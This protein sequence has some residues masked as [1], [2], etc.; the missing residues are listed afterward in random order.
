M[1]KGLVCLFTLLALAQCAMAQNTLVQLLSGS[2]KDHT[3][4]WQFQVSGGRNSGEWKTIPVPSSWEMQGFG[5]YRY[6]SDWDGEPAPD[7]QGKYKYSFFAPADWQGSAIEI[8]FGGVMTDAEVRVNGELLGPVHRGGFYEFRYPLDKHLHYGQS[9]LLEVNVSRFSENKSINLAE[10]RADFWMFSG[11]YRPVWVEVKPAQHIRQVEIKASHTGEFQAHLLVDGIQNADRISGQITRL[12]GKRVGSGFSVRLKPGQQYVDLHAQIDGVRP[13]SAEDP[14]RYKVVFELKA[15]RKVLHQVDEVFGFRT[16]EL[17]P[18]DGL[19]VNDQKVHLKG[20]NRHSFWPD[21]GATTSESISRNDIKLIKAMNMNAVRTAHAPP[22]RH[23]LDVADELGVYVLDELTGWQDAYD[24]YTGRVLVQEMVERDRNHPSVIMWA[25]GNEGG[26]NKSLDVDFARW[27]MQA[28]PVVHP[29]GVHGGI[30]ASHYE[31]YD[32]CAGSFFGGPELFMPT[33]FL[34]ALYDGGGGAGLDDWWNRMLQNPLAIG[35]FIWSFA[36]EGI[37]RDDKSGALDTAGNSAPDGVLGPYRE[38]EGSFYAIREIWSPVYFPLSE[39]SWLPSSFNGQLHVENRYDF[40]NLNQLTFTWELRDFNNPSAKGKGHIVKHTGQVIADNIAPGHSGDLNLKLPEDWHD[41]DS[42]ALTATNPQG[43]LIHTWTWMTLTPAE[44]AKRSLST[45]KAV[46]VVKADESSTAIKLQAGD[47]TVTIDKQSGRLA[48]VVRGDKQ[49]SL[50]N[51]PRLVSGKGALE[52][53]SLWWEGD[54]PVVSAQY[55]GEMSQVQWRLHPNGWLQMNYGY[56]LPSGIK[57]DYLGITF[58]Y[59]ESQALGITWLGRG[60]YRVWKNRLKGMAFDIWHTDY[61][62]TVTGQAGTY[63][64]FKGFYRD[65]YWGVLE[66]RELPITLAV[67]TENTFLRLFTPR[68]PA[69]P[70]QTHLQFPAGDISI[71]QGIAP[72]GTKFHTAD[73][74]GVQG[75]P[76]RIGRLGQSYG[77]ELYLYFGEPAN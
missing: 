61:N 10:R 74:M 52:N 37:V 58:D 46:G 5:S 64:E 72:I 12:D 55:K 23:F 59:P 6:W 17:R 62:D 49:V 1:L 70:A 22:D 50:S 18:R 60:P 48:R 76:N 3:V 19:Y 68:E 32:C 16:I 36:D 15:G 47:L 28:R 77:A 40:T 24:T 13:W 43:Q 71:L 9:N 11:I 67:N 26:W 75:A 73:E 56:H 14:Q 54:V 31:T 51:G 27:D 25:N 4:D 34:H 66:T 30:D 2:D 53:V 41:Y 35:G 7:R 69:N 63:P 42:L 21:T 45:T 38:K 29:W 57:A 8:V 65:F 33:E 20:V 39:L 44:T